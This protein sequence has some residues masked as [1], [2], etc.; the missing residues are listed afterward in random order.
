M[1]SVLCSASLRE[2]NDSF[3]LS[4][5]SRH[6][7]YAGHPSEDILKVNTRIPPCIDVIRGADITFALIATLDKSPVAGKRVYES[8]LA[9][10]VRALFRANADQLYLSDVSELYIDEDDGR[11]KFKV[12]S[13][14]QVRPEDCSPHL[15][16]V[17]I[18]LFFACSTSYE[19]SS[20]SVLSAIDPFSSQSYLPFTSLLQNLMRRFMTHHFLGR[21]PLIFG[22]C[23]TRLDLQTTTIPIICNALMS[24][25]GRSDNSA[26]RK[27]FRKILKRLE[28]QYSDA[29]SSRY[30]TL[31]KFLGYR[32]EGDLQEQR[33]NHEDGLDYEDVLRK[34]L[35]RLVKLRMKPT[36]FKSATTFASEEVDAQLGDFA[37]DPVTSPSS[38][39]SLSNDLALDDTST[40]SDVLDDLW[41]T[42]EEDQTH[43]A[44]DDLDWDADVLLLDEDSSEGSHEW[45]AEVDDLSPPDSQDSFQS[46]ELQEDDEILWPMD[47]QI[48]C[49]DDSSYTQD[50]PYT[51]P[52]DYD[53]ILMDDAEAYACDG[54]YSKD[55]SIPGYADP[56]ADLTQHMSMFEDDHEDDEELFDFE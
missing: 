20:H 24:M 1:P 51:Q 44:A 32:A 19:D 12:S 41:N 15:T 14:S 11:T 30:E 54:I 13:R 43:V 34:S 18:D 48:V 36:S 21:Y 5:T 23:C 31:A 3:I 39:T 10:Q 27:R 16:L 35:F 28:R 45:L 22:A 47:V 2:R 6:L 26:F 33:P 52:N 8:A 50:T 56:C 55:N 17:S 46:E 37:Q 9:S 53:S 40:I 25:Y 49:P 29:L 4:L 42:P 38:F 7:L